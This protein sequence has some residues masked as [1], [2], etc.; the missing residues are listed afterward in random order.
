MDEEWCANVAEVLPV[1]CLHSRS[2]F[3]KRQLRRA[4]WRRCRRRQPS[5]CHSSNRRASPVPDVWGPPRAIRKSTSAVW[6]LTRGLQLRSRWALTNGSA[7]SKLQQRLQVQ[8]IGW[9]LSSVS[10][11]MQQINPQLYVPVWRNSLAAVPKANEVDPIAVIQE[12]FEYCIAHML[13]MPT[14]P[15]SNLH[16]HSPVWQSVRCFFP[17]ISRLLRDLHSWWSS[18]Q[19]AGVLFCSPRLCR[20]IPWNYLGV[21]SE[22]ILSHTV[23]LFFELFYRMATSWNYDSA[24]ACSLSLT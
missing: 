8:P 9:Y 2:K 22:V 24:T 1:N 3:Q 23:F 21:C 12:A 14:S 4:Q 11:L 7:Q 5:Q 19:Q 20:E 6:H 17:P 18:R 13:L 15:H 10:Q 16:S